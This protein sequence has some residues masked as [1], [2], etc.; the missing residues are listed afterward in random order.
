[1]LATVAGGL[2]VRF[3]PLGLPPVVT[4]Y[5]GSAFWAL[6]I[7]WIVSAL[8]P[9]WRLPGV[10]VLAG[11]LAA[12]VE[13]F[14]LYRSPAVDAFRLTLPGTLLL[15]RFFSVW[16]IVAYWLAI[17]A[18][19]FAD[20]AFRTGRKALAGA[21]LIL[22]IAFGLVWALGGASVPVEHPRRGA[23]PDARD[24]A[25]DF[26]GDGTPDFLR[27]D[28]AHDTNAFRSW[29]VWLAEA[30]Y[31]QA[32]TAHRTEIDDC[33]ALIR[34]AYREALKA[35]D[36]AWANGSGLP[37]FPDYDSVAKY[38]YPY[39][40]LRAAL[41]RVRPGPF[42]ET[43]LKDGTFLQFADAQ[44][45]WR[46]NTHPV[47]RDLE[48]ALPGDLLF[49]RRGSTF[50]SMIYLGES[51]IRPDGHRYLLYHTGPAGKAPGE[52]RRP[53]V[54]E[55]M[56]FPQPEWRPVAA[57]PAFLGVARWNILRRFDE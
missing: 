53:A 26:A 16:D 51:R 57:N 8:L 33:A 55:L 14:K 35:H 28:D 42:R 47:G 7:Y 29:F 4:K 34:Y 24:F 10:V 52:L 2:A 36:S 17:I 5:G 25:R 18:G 46:L 1:M 22:T 9:A 40:P 44:T 45:L 37:E 56:R 32:A 31:F 30:T 50:H 48:R 15:G 11:S 19:A 39:T 6:M 49:F 12:A 54:E 43:D 23:T 27:L 3:A 41:F 38:H 13:F 20:R 21:G